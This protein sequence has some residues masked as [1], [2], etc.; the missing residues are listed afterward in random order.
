MT[1]SIT[2]ARQQASNFAEKKYTVGLDLG[3]RW[4][5]YCVL[6]ERGDVVFEHKLSTT[7]KALREVFGAMPHSRVA[8]ET[9][10][11]SPWVSRLIKELGHEVIVAQ[12]SKVRLIGESRKKDDRLDARTLARWRGSSQLLAGAAGARRSRV[13]GTNSTSQCPGASGF[14]HDPGESWPGA[15]ADGA[16]QCR[17]GFDEVL[18]GTITGLQPA[19]Y[20]RGEEEGIECGAAAGIGAAVA[21]DRVAQPADSGL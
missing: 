8:L 16:G 9:G 3:D 18:R 10:T 2:V 4:S 14:D 13:A 11:H 12:A 5:W 1:K 20:E 19:K 15:G 7:P 21:S 6:D 17:A